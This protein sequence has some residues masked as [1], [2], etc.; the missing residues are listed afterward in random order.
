MR[1]LRDFIRNEAGPCKTTDGV[2][3][4]VM[5]NEHG[6][7]QLHPCTSFGCG[8]IFVFIPNDGWVY[9]TNDMLRDRLQAQVKIAIDEQAPGFRPWH[10]VPLYD[11]AGTYITPARRL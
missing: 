8:A 7:M 4:K 6:E 10:S 9:I 1:T 5:T 11:E 3:L 2:Y